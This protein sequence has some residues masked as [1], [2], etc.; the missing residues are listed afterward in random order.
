MKKNYFFTTL[1]VIT[2]TVIMQFNLVAQDTIVQWTF[3]TESAMADGGIITSNLTQVIETAGGTSEIQFK[4]GS[5][6]KAAQATEWNDGADEKK[7]KVE[8]ETSGY[9][10]IS[11]SSKI[12]SGGNNPGPRDFRVQYKADGDWTDLEDSYFQTANDWTTGVLLNVA[13]PDVCDDQSSVKLRWIMTS[14]TA[15]DGTIVST[16][17]ISKIDDI[18]ITGDMIDG[19][20]EATLAQSIKVYPNPTSDFINIAIEKEAEVSLFDLTGKKLMM[21]KADGSTIINVSE[22]NSG[23]YFLRVVD[24]SSGV[25]VTKR[26]MIK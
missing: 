9:T 2:L 15:S 26:V 6:T 16:N 8:F 7:W 12:S 23:L 21:L 1:S 25:V 11:M 3:P 20:E 13:L 10:N 5:T 17:G 18:F 4:N 14:D 19:I 22:F 24:V